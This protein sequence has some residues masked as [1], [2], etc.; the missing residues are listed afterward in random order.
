MLYR[1]QARDAGG[2][3]IARQNL[4]LEQ[5]QMHVSNLVVSGYIVQVFRTTDT[6]ASEAVDLDDF[7]A[8]LGN[9]LEAVDDLTPEEADEWDDCPY[10]VGC[11]SAECHGDERPYVEDDSMRYASDGGDR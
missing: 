9:L 8:P 2:N 3:E 6:V 11:F 4:P 10:C 1:Y 5:A 7:F